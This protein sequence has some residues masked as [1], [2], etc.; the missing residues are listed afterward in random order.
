MK[1]FFGLVL[2]GFSSFVLAA[3]SSCSAS[4]SD[5]SSCSVSKPKEK[6]KTLQAE[7][8]NHL[9][10]TYSSPNGAVN[11]SFELAGNTIFTGSLDDVFHEISS[12]FRSRAKDGTQDV[13]C[14]CSEGKIPMADCRMY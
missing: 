14:S 12:E 8:L 10:F 7:N 6:E 13:S 4:C 3:G 9:E 5:G 1:Y 2:F 11:Y